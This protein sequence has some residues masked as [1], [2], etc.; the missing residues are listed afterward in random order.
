M[1]GFRNKHKWK[2]GFFVISLLAVAAMFL[3]V[4]T[5]ALAQDTPTSAD[6]RRCQSGT[7]LCA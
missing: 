3:G 6:T 4:T 1:I 2:V 7:L 5:P